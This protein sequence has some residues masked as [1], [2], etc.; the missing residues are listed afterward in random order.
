MW[1]KKLGK[2][3]TSADNVIT[4]KKAM[5]HSEESSIT[6]TASPLSSDES[7]NHGYV[8]LII[9]CHPWA[10]LVFCFISGC[11]CVLVSMLLP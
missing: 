1:Q 5:I 9:T 10:T 7:L 3:R 2:F 4:H 6:E 11:V 8:C